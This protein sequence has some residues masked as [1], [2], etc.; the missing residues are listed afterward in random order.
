MTI[1]YKKKKILHNFTC[2]TTVIVYT[3]REMNTDFKIENQQKYLATSFSIL[4][5]FFHSKN[6]SENKFLCRVSFHAQLRKKKHNH[7]QRT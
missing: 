5:K 3:L 2:F 7:T 4:Y 6:K 1:F